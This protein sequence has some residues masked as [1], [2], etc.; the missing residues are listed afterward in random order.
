[1]TLLLAFAI[2]VA[3]AA[4][5]QTDT[6]TTAAE[7]FAKAYYKLDPAMADHICSAQ[8]NGGGADIVEQYLHATRIEA[9]QR[10]FDLG[11]LRKRLYHIETAVISREAD[12][13]R[14]HLTGT[15]RTRINPV[16]AWVA[17]IFHLGDTHHVDEVIELVKE[18]GRWKVC[19]ALF[20]LTGQSV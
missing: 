11:M 19:G 16:Y 18:K 12:T 13:A 15:V 6:P 1:L 14:V 20:S 9:K 8:R 3:F 2:Q 17:N 5:D 10:G 7:E 4:A